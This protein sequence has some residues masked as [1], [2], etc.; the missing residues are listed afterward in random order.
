M[1]ID[2][3]GDPAV[4][5]VC[6]CVL[7][8]H[9]VETRRATGGSAHRT[10]F[11]LSNRVWTLLTSSVWGFNST[12]R[13]RKSNRFRTKM[14]WSSTP[15]LLLLLKA[16][17][18]NRTEPNRTGVIHQDHTINFTFSDV[19]HLIWEFPGFYLSLKVDF[20]P[21]IAAD[22]SIKGPVCSFSNSRILIFTLLMTS[23]D[24]NSDIYDSYKC[25]KK[26]NKVHRC[27]SRSMW[28]FQGRKWLLESNDTE[29]WCLTS[30]KIFVFTENDCCCSLVQFPV[31]SLDYFLFFC[32]FSPSSPLLFM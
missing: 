23:Q 21:F 18:H 31:T 1:D 32:Y 30:I 4:L 2:P 26:D 14:A 13:E 8:R 27:R 6:V 29:N 28:L 7:S 24:K 16:S 22:A 15:L 9:H 12:C 17:E 25:L 11:K 20:Q 5:C 19:T 3:V 10:T